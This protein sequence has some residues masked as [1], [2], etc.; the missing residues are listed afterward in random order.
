V[1]D[2]VFEKEK[3]KIEKISLSFSFFVFFP[4]RYPPALPQQHRKHQTVDIPA[5]SST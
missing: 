1:L 4:D 2:P 3:E 5:L